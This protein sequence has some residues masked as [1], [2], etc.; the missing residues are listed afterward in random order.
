MI[1][2]TPQQSFNVLDFMTSTNYRDRPVLTNYPEFECCFLA[3]HP[4]MTIKPGHEDKI[5]FV[6]LQWPDKQAIEQHCNVVTWTEFLRLSGVSGYKKLNQVLLF[7]EGVGVR[8]GNRRE[9]EKAA[10]VLKSH[11]II[12]AQPHDLPEILENRI[13]KYLLDI[14]Y[15][16]VVVSSNIDDPATI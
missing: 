12:S 3:L 6:P 5:K 11:S 16:Q 14:G 13:L 4:F 8:Y 2:E 10:K 9:V 1:L 7:R 15:K